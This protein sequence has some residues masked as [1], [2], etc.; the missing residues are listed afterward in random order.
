MSLDITTAI[1]YFYIRCSWSVWKNT[2]IMKCMYKV[3]TTNV[4]YFPLHTH[5]CYFY[6]KTMNI[7]NVS[8]SLKQISF[9]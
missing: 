2:F 4:Q 3:I 1:I 7:V 5:L 8:T 6:T 9:H